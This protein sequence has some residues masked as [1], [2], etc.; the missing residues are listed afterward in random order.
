MQMISIITIISY[1]QSYAKND[2]FRWR[3][4]IFSGRFLL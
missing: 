3:P 1:Q 4:E 2:L